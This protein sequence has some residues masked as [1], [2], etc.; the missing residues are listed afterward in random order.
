MV[1]AEGGAG[2]KRHRPRKRNMQILSQTE[3]GIRIVLYLTL[4]GHARRA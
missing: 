1:P 4:A 2:R 3:G